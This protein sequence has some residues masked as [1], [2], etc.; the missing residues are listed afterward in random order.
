MNIEILT[1]LIINLL[2]VMVNNEN[3]NGI[4]KLQ[5]VIKCCKQKE[6][7]PKLL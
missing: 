3:P 4:A 6:V 2:A 1:H 7:F 5:Q